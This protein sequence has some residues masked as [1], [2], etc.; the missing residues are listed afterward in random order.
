V[1]CAAKVGLVRYTLRLYASLSPIEVE[2]VFGT[3]SWRGKL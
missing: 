2:T 3:P 1:R